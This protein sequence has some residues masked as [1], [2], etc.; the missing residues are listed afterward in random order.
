[1]Q[2]NDQ[3]KSLTKTIWIGFD[4]YDR[5]LFVR[6]SIVRNRNRSFLLLGNN[7]NTEVKP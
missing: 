7:K 5:A 6:Q 2:V 1:M 3:A 4:L